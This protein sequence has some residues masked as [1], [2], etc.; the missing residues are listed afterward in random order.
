VLSLA[1]IGLLRLYSSLQ[2]VI[3]WQILIIA[4]VIAIA[5]GLFFG[6][7]PALKAARK[8]PIEALRHE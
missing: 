4:P 5:I 8:D 7:M 6:G 3:V 1:A 2:P